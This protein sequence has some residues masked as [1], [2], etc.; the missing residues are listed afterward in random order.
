MPRCV[1]AGLVLWAAVVG[2]AVAGPFE[3]GVAAFERGDHLEAV[4]S[5]RVIAEQGDRDGQYNMGV[6]YAVGNGVP[7]DYVLA[8]MWF[9]LAA[10]QGD[11]DAAK[12]RVKLARRMTPDQVAEAQRMAREWRPSQ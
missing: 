9:N 3:D 12:E 11:A 4:R 5:W 2:A 8:H 7:Q 10:A 1:L 6:M